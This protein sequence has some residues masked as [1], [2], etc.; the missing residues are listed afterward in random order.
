MQAL[1]TY[2]YGR[3]KCKVKVEKLSGSQFCMGNRMG[4]SKI[5][6]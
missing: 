2:A 3:F 5:K 4:P 1:E 6:D